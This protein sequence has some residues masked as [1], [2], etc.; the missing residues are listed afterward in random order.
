M[1]LV[2]RHI[3]RGGKEKEEKEIRDVKRDSELREKGG[4]RIQVRSED[5]GKGNRWR[6][7]G[8]LV[9]A[10]EE[11]KGSWNTECAENI[12]DNGKTDCARAKANGPTSGERVKHSLIRSRGE[13]RVTRAS[14]GAPVEERMRYKDKRQTATSPEKKTATMKTFGE[15]R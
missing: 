6:K 14:Y 12:A 8:S 5:A 4:E 1:S 7:T 13:R 11:R 9:K 3:S 10:R 2:G 15:E